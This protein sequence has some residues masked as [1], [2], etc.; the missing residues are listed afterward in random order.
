MLLDRYNVKVYQAGL[1]FVLA[2]AVKNVFNC[3]VSFPH[4]LDKGLYTQILSNR[5]L[6]QF[7]I[8]NLKREMDRI[9]H[10]DI[11][12]TKKVVAK[13][14]AY[15]FYMKNEEEEKAGNICNINN[16]TVTLYELDGQH[17]YFM[18]S[19]PPSTGK[20]KYYKL[21]FLGNNDLVLSV[22]IDDTGIIPDYVAQEKIFESFRMYHKW[23]R[24]LGVKYVYDLNNIISNN[25]I[26]DFIKKNDIMMD[27]QLY[28][29]A[30][31]IK[32]SKKKIILLGGPSSSGKTTSTK[33]LALFLE[34]F[35]LNPIYLGLDD[36]F[37]N[38]KD[39]PVDKNG[40]PN[41]EGIEAIDLELFNNH[42]KRML[43]GEAVSVPTFNF[44]TGEKEYKNRIIKLEEKDI[45]LIEGLHTLNEEL[46]KGISKDQKL[47]IYIS[48]FTPLGIDRHNH[49]S[50]I[51]IRLLRRI[52]R[53]SWSR[54]YTAEQTLKMWDKVREGEVKYVFPYTNEAD[55]ILNTAFIYEIGVLKVYAEPLL[56]S[57]T[58]ES[59]YYNEARRI[60]DFLQMFFP[61]SSEFVSNDNI[62]REFIGGS[63]FEGR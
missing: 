32:E 24:T 51:D 22:P 15:N 44:I 17:N 20:L 59:K 19:M 41:F 63:Y 1:K 16:K 26:K 30:A 9:I 31:R 53:D 34:T 6:S 3:E 4:S 18:G 14:D 10:E 39:S 29:A 47:K 11:K 13:N 57:I 21:T 45:I 60:I 25:K 58:P 40:E 28:N 8:D 37:K 49:L 46:T 38:R 62:L 7:D 33:K 50:T 42:L 56:Y 2:V 36:Y 23:I 43:S 54:G 61:I 12:I 48:P 55:F 27:N 5:Q 52:I 35:G